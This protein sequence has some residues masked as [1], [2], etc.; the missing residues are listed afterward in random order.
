MPPGGTSLGTALVRQGTPVDQDLPTESQ[1]TSQETLMTRRANR[2]TPL[3]Q[4]WFSPILVLA[5]LGAAPAGAAEALPAASQGNAP[6]A[7][8]AG[9]AAREAVPPVRSVTFDEALGLAAEAPAAEQR[10]IA[11]SLS[12][13][14]ANPS[15]TLQ[16]G[17]ARDPLDGRVSAMGEA[18]LLQG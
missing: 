14:V 3:R 5:L 7:G 1:E 18:T 17:A 10:R 13:L 9:A 2:G 12:S 11:A 16:P 8:P 6:P 4:V 15:L